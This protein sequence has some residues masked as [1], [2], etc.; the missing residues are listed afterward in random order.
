MLSKRKKTPLP[1]ILIIGSDERVVWPLAYRLSEI[2]FEVFAE[3]DGEGGFAAALT[4]R[5]DVV[6]LDAKLTGRD[7]YAICSMLRAKS[8]VARTPVIMLTGR[9]APRAAARAQAAGADDSIARPIDE[10]TLLAKM[11]QVLNRRVRALAA[12][13]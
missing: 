7:G 13:A 2:G 6:L 11:E 3:A 4:L 8:K 12:A 9:G 10:R 1:R 5:P